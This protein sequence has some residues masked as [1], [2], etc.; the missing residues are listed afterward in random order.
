VHGVPGRD[1]S[2]DQRLLHAVQ[3][4]QF[5]LQRGMRGGRWATGSG[6]LAMRSTSPMTRLSIRS[7]NS[8]ASSVSGSQ[9]LSEMYSDDDWAPAQTILSRSPTPTPRTFGASPRT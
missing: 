1:R 3:I 7:G 2:G 6:S 8:A 9:V 4:I 5:A